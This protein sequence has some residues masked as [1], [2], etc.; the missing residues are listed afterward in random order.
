MC[1]NIKNLYNFDPPVTDREIRDASLKFVRQVSGTAKP[2]KINQ[3]VFDQAIVEIS[4]SVKKLL[5]LMVTSS[6]PKNRDV[7][8]AKAKA[9]S[10]KRFG[11]RNSIGVT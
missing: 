5:D 9:K 8:A 1:R 11:N 7:E 3:E 2:S 10:A 6:P 4:D